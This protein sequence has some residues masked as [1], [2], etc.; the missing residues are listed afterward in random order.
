MTQI[1][2]NWQTPVEPDLNDTYMSSSPKAV[3]RTPKAVKEIVKLIVAELGKETEL[4]K[5]NKQLKLEVKKL[6]KQVSEQSERAD[7]WRYKATKG[8]S[9]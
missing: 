8:V 1:K 4:Q 6:R 2:S 3:W 7:Q 5:E 9:K